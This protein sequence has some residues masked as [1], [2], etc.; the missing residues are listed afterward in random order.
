MTVVIAPAFR[1]L[2]LAPYLDSPGRAASGIAPAT[3][4]PALSHL[5]LVIVSDRLNLAQLGALALLRRYRP[6]TIILF[7]LWNDLDEL[8]AEYQQAR[9][10]RR[11][12]LRSLLTSERLFIAGPFAFALEGLLRLRS[13]VSIVNVPV[14]LK[15]PVENLSEGNRSDGVRR[16]GASLRA[17]PGLVRARWRA[18]EA[19]ALTRARAEARAA[20]KGFDKLLVY[21]GEIDLHENQAP[22]GLDEELS[23]IARRV[24]DGRSHY[25]ELEPMI[26]GLA[27]CSS[28][29][30]RVSHLVEI[31]RNRIRY[32]YLR[33]LEAL[34]P[35]QLV[36]VGDAFA[37]LGFRSV[38]RTAHSPRFR[39][40]MY[41]RSLVSIDL[42]SRASAECLY[43]RSVEIISYGFGLIQLRGSDSNTCYGPEQRAQRVFSG[44]AE[45]E[46]RVRGLFDM[47][48]AD[49]VASGW[50]L[51]REVSAKIATRNAA[52]MQTIADERR[53]S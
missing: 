39:R 47:S 30:L 48:T 44:T 34:F 13:E 46:E 19:G 26:S 36:V 10:V 53:P 17:L 15:P 37:R 41:Q 4:S 45:M 16:G 21:F 14:V 25:A 40:E 5:P 3:G 23:R 6:C 31:A 33:A 20:R 7:F 42:L 52:V 18:R 38:I 22:S 12:L 27:E 50:S 24:L 51:R 32:L 9:S 8:T 49:F 11:R 2:M 43:P 35:E 29:S 28:T 1:R